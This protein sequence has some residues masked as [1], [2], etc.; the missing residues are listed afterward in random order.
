MAEPEIIRSPVLAGTAHGFFGRA[1]GVSKGEVAGL[2]AGLGAGDDPDAV[3]RNRKIV[4][5]CVMPGADLVMPYQVH[6][7]DV[8]VVGGA[9]DLTS[10]PRVDALVTNRPGILLGIVT[11]DCAPV[12]LYDQSAGIIGAAHAG[13]K[14]AHAGIVENTAEAMISSGAQRNRI[15]AAIGPCIAQ[16]SYEVDDAFRAQFTNEEG[17]FF[18]AGKHGHQ[19]FDLEGYVASRLRLAGIDNIH[20][21][22]ADTYADP[23]RF[24]SYRRATHRGA[25]TYGRQI[26]VIGLGR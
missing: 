25:P 8:A 17:Q 18:G 12:L 4:S 11:A 6:S 3:T 19:Q 24:Y 15:C 9:F 5:D 26:S 14:G 22:G 16:A 13:W 23:E 7:A 21:L 20:A 10:R 1:G 2:N